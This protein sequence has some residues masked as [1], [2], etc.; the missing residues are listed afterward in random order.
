MSFGQVVIFIL[1]NRG[2]RLCIVIGL[3][4]NRWCNGHTETDVLLCSQSAAAQVE[5]GRKSQL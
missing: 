5:D 3:N 4:T 1:S 2:E